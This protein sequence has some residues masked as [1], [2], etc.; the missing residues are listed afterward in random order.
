MV[1]FQPCA[2]WPSSLQNASIHT[3]IVAGSFASL[4]YFVMDYFV[5]V[6][7]TGLAYDVG[8]SSSMVGS[9]FLGTKT[10]FFG[11]SNIVPIR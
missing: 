2:K 5:I 4:L 9:N 7:T 6:S 11:F 1:V 8:A 3:S 10:P